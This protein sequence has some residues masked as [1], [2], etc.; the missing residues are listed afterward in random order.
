MGEK[1][2]LKLIVSLLLVCLVFPF[3][4]AQAQTVEDNTSQNMQNV[5]PNM[6]Q[7]RNMNGNMT[8]N[9]SNV[10]F[11]LQSIEGV[12]NNDTTGERW[13]TYINGT[14]AN[15]DFGLNN[16]SNG[17]NLSFWYT[18]STDGRASIENAT[19]VANIT[20]SII[21]LAGNQTDNQT[22][23]QTAGNQTGG[24]QISGNQTGQ[25]FTVFYNNTV[26]LTQG[27]F[28]F[29]PENLTQTY[30][31]DNLTDLGALNATGLVFNA[32]LMENMTGNMTQNM[33]GAGDNGNN[34]VDNTGN[35]MTNGG[36]NT[37]N[38]NTDTSD[39]NNNN[40]GDDNSG[41]TEST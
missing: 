41:G 1:M 8:E 22:G 7:Q 37:G 25:N 2:S 12:R 40:A 31:V 30:E 13:F 32:S 26:N 38:S 34:G 36:S 20:V 4:S 5:S 28:T 23:N 27:N 18:N 19:Y 35:S 15:E 29:R 21:P 6:S 33:T 24:D 39:D 17:T 10:P 9:I 11:M 14:Q 3:G 16:V